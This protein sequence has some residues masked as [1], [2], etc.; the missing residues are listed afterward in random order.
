MGLISQDVNEAEGESPWNFHSYG[1][2]Q[3]VE[4]RVVCVWHSINKGEH[5]RMVCLIEGGILALPAS[6]VQK[7]NNSQGVFRHDWGAAETATESPY[8]TF[9]I[10]GISV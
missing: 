8:G 5:E 2:D 10:L 6:C 3:E 7:T 1:N 9:P 4:R